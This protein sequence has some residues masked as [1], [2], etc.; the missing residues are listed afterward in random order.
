MSK[1]IK[2]S[3]TTMSQHCSFLEQLGGSN[4]VNNFRIAVYAKVLKLDEDENQG[5]TDIATLWGPEISHHSSKEN[6]YKEDGL[7]RRNLGMPLTAPENSEEGRKRV[8]FDTGIPTNSSNIY[9]DDGTEPVVAASMEQPA[10]GRESFNIDEE[11]SGALTRG[12][13]RQK[14][15]VSEGTQGENIN[16]S[17]NEDPTFES[18]DDDG[19]QRL[20]EIAD[21]ESFR[22]PDKTVAT[23][24]SYFMEGNGRTRHPTDMKSRGMPS[25]NGRML[26]KVLKVLFD[27]RKKVMLR[28]GG[29]PKAH[30]MKYITLIPTA[31]RHRNVTYAKMSLMTDINGMAWTINGVEQTMLELGKSDRNK[32][33][34]TF[35]VIAIL[36]HIQP[37]IVSPILREIA[38]EGLSSVGCTK[39]SY[40]QGI[41]ECLEKKRATVNLHDGSRARLIGR[42]YVDPFSTFILG[43]E[44]KKCS[45]PVQFTEL[46]V[47]DDIIEGIKRAEL[48]QR[49]VIWKIS[50]VEKQALLGPLKE[51]FRYSNSA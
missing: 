50:G 29:N 1:I 4:E 33:E 51:Q 7:Q 17:A 8:S 14:G 36:L 19:V 35:S 11:V 9:D 16:K 20:L 22:I 15:I 30:G 39:W 38:I 48:M 28:S 44:V 18:N 12:G 31:L 42:G 40:Y 27:L 6:S 25:I 49:A 10:N 5:S 2:S 23:C 32:K 46:F 43:T 45:I 13:N 3:L 41:N 21:S 24:L 26:N 37:E 47:E 34:V